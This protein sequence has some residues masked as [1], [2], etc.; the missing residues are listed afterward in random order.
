MKHF[1]FW[2][3]IT[4]EYSDICGEEFLVAVEGVNAFDARENAVQLA[5]S[6]F[7]NEERITCY[8]KVSAAQAEMMGLDIY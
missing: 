7:F 8:G 4:N 6:I 1:Y 3:G 5:Q 2:F